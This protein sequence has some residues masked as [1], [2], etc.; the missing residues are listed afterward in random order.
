[1]TIDT[2]FLVSTAALLVCF[3][4]SSVFNPFFRRPKKEWTEETIADEGEKALWPDLSVVVLAHG[5]TDHLEQHLLSIL[6]QE[7]RGSF[8]VVVVTEQGDVEAENVVKLHADDRRLR[9]TYIP[10]RSLFMSRR[11]LAVLLGVKAAKGEWIVLIDANCKPTSPLWLQAM[12]RQCTDDKNVVIGYSNYPQDSAKP[13]YRFARLRQSCYALR[14]AQKGSAYRSTGTNLAFR[15]ALFIEQ[16]G[17]RDNLQYV[18][19]EYDFI[20]SKLGKGDAA[21]TAISPEAMIEQD[22]PSRKVWH[23]SCVGYESIRRT[24]H[25]AKWHKLL[26]NLD[27]TFMY[28]AYLLDLCAIIYGSLTARWLLMAVAAALFILTVFVRLFLV[29]KTIRLFGEHIAQW[30]VFGYELSLGFRNLYYRLSFL[31]SNKRDFTTHKL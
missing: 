13:W 15:K 11:K 25:G 23:D 9:S 31:T 5:V 7:Y 26:L 27:L 19:G 20:V 14:A 6:A 17:F 3:L 28:A 24:L 1:M 21:A 10:S 12:A 2:F 8:D 22:E 29:H 30:R 18:F 4:L 16:D